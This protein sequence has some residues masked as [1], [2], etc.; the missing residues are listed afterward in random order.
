MVGG[1]DRGMALWQG[2]RQFAPGAM[3]S[4]APFLIFPEQP[5]HDQA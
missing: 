1:F 3:A 4:D 5:S 2:A